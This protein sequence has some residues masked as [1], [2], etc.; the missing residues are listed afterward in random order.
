M[1]VRAAGALT[2][3]GGGEQRSAG[4]AAA[5]CD[6]VEEGSGWSAGALIRGPE[7]PGLCLF[8]NDYV[9]MAH[10]AGPG[11]KGRGWEGS[12]IDECLYQGWRLPV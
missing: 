7:L 6:G 9:I 2:G 11:L 5:A 12:W 3:S 10:L 1:P 8:W 4:G